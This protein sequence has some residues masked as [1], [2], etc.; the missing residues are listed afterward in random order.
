M[1]RSTYLHCDGIGEVT[2]QRLWAAG[3]LTWDDFLRAPDAGRLSDHLRADLVNLVTESVA[4]LEARDAAWFARQL[5][6]REHWRAFRA[7]RDGVAYLDIETT[8]GPE[9]EDLTVVGLYDGVRLQ[10]FV[11][12]EN[13]QDFPAAMER[14]EVIVTFFGGGFDLPFLRRAYRME[15]PQLHVD[16]CPLWQR[17]G[18]RG[19]LKRVEEA[20]GIRRPDQTRGLSG[21]DA[22]RLWWEWRNNDNR[23]ALETLLAYNADD[24]LNMERLIDLALPLLL[25]KAGALPAA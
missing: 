18:Y 16:L 21:L 2:E 13:L 25:E 6:G 19:G 23:T 22:V 14:V 9:P 12:G 15:F 5:P 20:L 1:L 10:Q 7:F 8:G 3:A 17:L 24:V 11:R 4:R